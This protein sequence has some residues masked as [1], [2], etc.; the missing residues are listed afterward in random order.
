MN[1]QTKMSLGGP[2]GRWTE[3]DEVAGIIENG[4]APSVEETSGSS[5]AICHDGPRA[6]RQVSLP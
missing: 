3:R 2:A 5:D 4:W 1:Q 6:I